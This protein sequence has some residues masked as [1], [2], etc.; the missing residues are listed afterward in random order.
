MWP[1]KSAPSVGGQTPCPPRP[2]LDVGPP[3]GGAAADRP[4]R[5]REPEASGAPLVDGV[6]GHGEPLRDL[7]H[8]DRLYHEAHC[9]QSLDDPPKCRH[10]TDTTGS[11]PGAAPTARGLAT[12]EV[13]VMTIADLTRPCPG[14]APPPGAGRRQLVDGDAGCPACSA[15]GELCEFHR[16]WAEGWDACAAY[17]AGSVDIRRDAGGAS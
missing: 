17:V 3:P 15:A 8:A 2:F 4:A 11:G 14:G 13:A 9:R 6:T 7:D 5:L 1:L 16:G 10:N 12:T